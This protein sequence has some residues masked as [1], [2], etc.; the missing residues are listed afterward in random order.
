MGQYNLFNAVSYCNYAK[1]LMI[2]N[3]QKT[4][5]ESLAKAV[6]IFACLS[7]DHPINW[8]VHFANGIFYQHKND[9]GEAEKLF[10]SCL[11][12]AVKKF[13]SS[14]ITLKKVRLRIAKVL[15]KLGNIDQS[16]KCLEQLEEEVE[17]DINQSRVRIEMEE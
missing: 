15:L 16:F 13:D 6:Q 4:A 11:S 7:N 17:E 1:Y 12:M 8:V 3:Q 5:S 9:L 10:K 2:L 14:H